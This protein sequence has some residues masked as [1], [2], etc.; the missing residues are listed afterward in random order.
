MLSVSTSI[1]IGNQA[2]GDGG[3][4]YLE[5]TTATLEQNA[6]LFNLAMLGNDVFSTDSKISR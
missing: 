1:F 4:I 6:F 5:A 2:A 3:A